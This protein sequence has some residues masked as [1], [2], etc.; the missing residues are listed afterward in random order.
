MGDAVLVSFQANNNFDDEEE[1]ENENARMTRQKNLLVRRAV[2]C[3]L[4][5][6]ARQSHYRV[7]LTAEERSKYRTLE[8]AL[9][10]SH[11]PNQDGQS[12]QQSNSDRFFI[13]D[14][15]GN[16]TSSET[17]LSSK[18]ISSMLYEQNDVEGYSTA[19][20]FWNLIPILFGKGRKNK[21][22]TARRTSDTSDT[23]RA[24]EPNAID[25]ELHIAIS[26]G[27]I[28]NIILGDPK[29]PVSETNKKQKRLSYINTNG[30]GIHL[31]HTLAYNGRLEYAICGPAVESL[32]DALSAAKAGE[33]SIT[34]E[35]YQLFQNQSMSLTYEKRS[36]F[37]IVKSFSGT[38]SKKR[39][40]QH[41]KP[42]GNYLADRPGLL[43]RAA[44]LNIEPLIPRTRETSFLE[45][46]SDPNPNYLKYINRS[47]LY[48]LQHS[49]DDNFAAQFRDAT[50]MFISLG[51]L[52]PAT[53][54]GLAI[55][56]KS[57]YFTIQT[58]IKY[59]GTRLC[60]YINLRL[61]FHNY[62]YFATICC[63]RQRSNN[64]SC[65]WLTTTITRTRI[66]LCS[67]SSH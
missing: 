43:T 2:E 53:A 23:T 47:A 30:S 38:V 44:T 33:M 20:N 31:D 8:H 51:K 63:R 19:F 65:I 61:N 7:Y 1:I 6:L 54:E 58:L 62:R 56:Q 9:E 25:L 15:T 17:S 55:A 37:Y 4:Q 10:S 66:H 12:S 11:H 14:E 48:R 36:Q 29:T 59:E 28:T 67:K 18:S 3:G 16:T 40:R 41:H 22:Y 50:I 35:A 24:T 52:N 60:G 39:T 42:N 13:F 32:E 5:L 46:S 21:V 64:I 34:A 57:V 49:P 26:C 27:M 45:L